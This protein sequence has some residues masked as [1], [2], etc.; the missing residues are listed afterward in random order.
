MQIPTRSPTREGTRRWKEMH[1]QCGHKFVCMRN[2][3]ARTHKIGGDHTKDKVRSESRYIHQLR[4][5]N[6]Q[7]QHVNCS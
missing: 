7:K 2:L 3:I 6:R 5:I 4:G 1:L